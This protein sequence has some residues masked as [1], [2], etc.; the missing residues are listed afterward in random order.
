MHPTDGA[1]PTPPITDVLHALL[2]QRGDTL[3]G[4]PQGSAEEGELAAI[5]GAIEAYEAGRWL[6]ERTKDGKG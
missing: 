3:E 5:I 6:L 1:S 4:C 2:V